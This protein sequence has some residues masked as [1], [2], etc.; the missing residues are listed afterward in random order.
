[1]YNGPDYGME[2]PPVITFSNTVIEPFAMMVESLSASIAL[3]AMLALNVSSCIA[4]CTEVHNPFN[5]RRYFM[6]IKYL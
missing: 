2:K 6:P 5:F 4:E 1:M 3:G